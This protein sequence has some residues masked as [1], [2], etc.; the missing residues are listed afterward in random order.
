MVPSDL[1]WS[2]ILLSKLLR[3]QIHILPCRTRKSQRLSQSSLQNDF[4]ICDIRIKVSDVIPISRIFLWRSFILMERLS[5]L[6]R[7]YCTIGSPFNRQAVHIKPCFFSLLLW[8]TEYTLFHLQ[9][10]GLHIDESW[11]FQQTLRLSYFQIC[12]QK[13]VCQRI[14][15]FLRFFVW[16]EFWMLIIAMHVRKSS[17]LKLNRCAN[18]HTIPNILPFCKPSNNLRAF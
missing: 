9:Y 15:L 18:M 14:L 12:K 7:F 17:F 8:K 1:F 6:L 13:C 3:L 11:T 4:T 5:H 10:S 2:Q 16:C